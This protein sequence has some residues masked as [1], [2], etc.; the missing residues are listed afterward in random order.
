LPPKPQTDYRVEATGCTAPQLF[1]TEYEPEDSA[2]ANVGQSTL[3]Q[4]SAWTDGTGW[5]DVNGTIVGWEDWPPE[6][7]RP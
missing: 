6:D 4:L 7:W 5:L 2:C 3:Q 1:I